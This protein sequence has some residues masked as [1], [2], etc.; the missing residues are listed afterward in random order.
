MAIA[1]GCLRGRVGAIAGDFFASGEGARV[2]RFLVGQHLTG[3]GFWGAYTILFFVN[4]FL[5]LTIG[6]GLL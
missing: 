1:R 3:V 4:A 5:Y 6:M 2:V